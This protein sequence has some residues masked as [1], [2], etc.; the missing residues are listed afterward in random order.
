MFKEELILKAGGFTEGATAQRVEISR[1]VGNSNSTTADAITAEVFQIDVDKNMNFSRPKFELQP[2]DIFS[3]RSS[4]G[5]EV[6]RQV[7]VEGEVLYPRMHTITNKDERFSDLFAKVFNKHI[8]K[9]VNDF[10][11]QTTTKKSLAN[12]SILQHQTAQSGTH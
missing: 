11:V 4:I 9:T 10:Y 1:W 8:V 3:V 5:Y 2:F 12:L 7:K 6:Q